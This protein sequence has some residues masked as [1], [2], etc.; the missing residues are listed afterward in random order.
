V[1]TAV[2]ARTKIVMFSFV[3]N[4]NNADEITLSC[5]L[6]CHEEAELDRTTGQQTAPA[7]RLVAGEICRPVAVCRLAQHHPSA[8]SKIERGSIGIVDYDLLFI[9]AALR[10]HFVHQ[11]P[12]IDRQRLMDEIVHRHIPHE[13]HDYTTEP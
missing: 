12:E 2:N 4:G 10:V 7:P 8:V 6:S 11:Y 1:K 5:S 13:L 3:P 9:A